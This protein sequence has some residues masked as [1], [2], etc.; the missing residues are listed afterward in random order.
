MCNSPVDDSI[1]ALFSTPWELSRAST[2]KTYLMFGDRELTEPITVFGPNWAK[3]IGVLGELSGATV[4][5]Y[6]LAPEYLVHLRITVLDV[7]E[8]TDTVIADEGDERSQGYYSIMDLIPHKC[9][10]N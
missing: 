4:I 9:K 1:S 2:V 8:N 6:E 3:A 5:L 10:N 7:T